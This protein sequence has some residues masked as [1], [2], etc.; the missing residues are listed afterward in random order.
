MIRGDDKHYFIADR[1][2]FN[3]LKGPIRIDWRVC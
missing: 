2:I 3:D 1:F